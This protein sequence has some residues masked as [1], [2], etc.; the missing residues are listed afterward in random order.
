MGGL[1]KSLQSALLGQFGSTA[2]SF[3]SAMLLARLVLPEAFGG[4]AMLSVFSSF[5][6]MLAGMGTGESMIQGQGFDKRVFNTIF[7][8]NVISASFWSMF[9]LAIAPLIS[10]WYEVG[11]DFYLFIGLAAVILLNGIQYAYAAFLQREM[12]FAL[13]WRIKI[14]AQL[15]SLG[16]AVCSIHFFGGLAG[17]MAKDLVVALVT[18]LAVIKV[19]R[20]SPEFSFSAVILRK[21]LGFGV[22]VIVNQVLG[23][24]VRN[25]D[26]FSIG[27][28]AG[29]EALGLYTKSYS[30]LLFPV[31]KVSRALS[32]V[33]F[34]W[35]SRQQGQPKVLGKAYLNLVQVISLLV[36]PLMGG[37]SLYAATF[38]MIVFGENWLAAEKVV[39]VLAIVGGLQSI[40]T[41]S[42]LAFQSTG[43]VHLAMKIGL[44]VKP[45]IILV[46]L[47][48]AWYTH[49]LYAV[50]VAYAGISGVMFFPENWF[51][52]KILGF[53]LKQ[54][55]WAIAP[56][57]M[58]TIVAAI[59]GCAMLNFDVFTIEGSL[60]LSTLV[61]LFVYFGGLYVFYPNELNT[62]KRNLLFIFQGRL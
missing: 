8:W 54:F 50:A 56:A 3:F 37:V 35:F 34:P 57:L 48:T 16:V 30:I 2:I 38:I 47:F 52:A 32:Q 14:A 61:Y 62:L 7:W 49:D 1:K 53:S 42:G 4:L 11:F 26:D 43:Q 40:G 60:F 45:L 55:F 10:A 24:A 31:A 41:L 36:F 39:A 28:W 15:V 58:L 22:R 46:V 6:I 12:E 27:K 59:S 13:I 19:S 29:K 17:L 21:H 25:V 18:T 9:F 23:Y 51:V 5:L 33:Y 44:F 20:I